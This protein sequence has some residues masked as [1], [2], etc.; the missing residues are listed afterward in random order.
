MITDEMARPQKFSAEI[1]FIKAENTGPPAGGHQPLP[2]EM[3]F[4]SP[5]SFAR[6]LV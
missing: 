4:L 1:F 3:F 2:A 6:R 5:H